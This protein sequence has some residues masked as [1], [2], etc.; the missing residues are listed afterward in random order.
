MRIEPA[1]LVQQATQLA[2]AVAVLLDRVFVVDACDQALV[3]DEQQ[4]QA[5]CFVDATALGFD[6]AVFDLVAH[7][8]AMPAADAVGFQNQFNQVGKNHAVERDRATFFKAHTNLFA[9]DFNL[10]LPERHAHDRLHDF[11]AAVQK[12]QV[13]GLVGGTQHVGVG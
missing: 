1:A 12:L 7:A 3:G 6:D 10:V 13:L 4:R 8:Q 5:G 11:H 9:F 2:A